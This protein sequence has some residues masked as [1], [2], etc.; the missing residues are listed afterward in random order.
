MK[1]LITLFI[2]T[3]AIAMG[4]SKFG[5]D[6]E[7]DLKGDATISGK[8][9]YRDNISGSG[10]LK[11]MG[12]RKIFIGKD[13]TDYNNYLYY[14]ITDAQGNFTFQRLN[15]NRTYLIYVND[16]I[17]EI[18]YSMYQTRVAPSDTVTLIA[19]N[20]TI[21][22]NGMLLYVL[23]SEHQPVKDAKV[24]LYNNKEIFES[25]TA[26]NTNSIK[27]TSTDQYG[28][29]IFYNYKA[30]TYYLRAK[31][32]SPNGIIAADTGFTFS[33]K[34]I[35]KD[36]ILLSTSLS[37]KNTLVLKVV[38]EAGIVLPGIT[39]CIF[40]NPLLF[41]QENCDGKY[42]QKESGDDGM[43]KLTNLRPGDYYVYAQTTTNKLDY[44]GKAN[45]KVNASGTTTSTIVMKPVTTN[46]LKVRTLDE[47]GNL[48]PGIDFCVFNNPLR[49]N[50][51]DCTGHYRDST[52][53]NDGTIKLNNIPA[54]S[55]YLYATVAIGNTQYKAKATVAVN[56]P[57][58][59]T[60]DLI[61]KKET[62]SSEVLLTV[63]DNAG[64]PV[65]GTD[66][67]FFTSRSLWLAD[68][69]TGSVRDTTTGSNG[70]VTVLNMPPGKYYLQ[71]RVM[72]N[73]Q[74]FMKGM[75][76]VNIP[77]APAKASQTI[78]VK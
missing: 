55:Y 8:I 52:T 10:E 74:L 11:L 20:D 68:N 13:T 30:G 12:G 78:I 46:T 53:S 61:L 54:G 24:W 65:N 35:Q 48:V 27:D 28:R 62:P 14:T 33:G 56:N 18:H 63:K 26:N 31:F 51:E 5:N 69:G 75:D 39:C 36:T 16:T 50:Q 47:A 71:A 70:S 44:K 40:N 19:E 45:I 67:Y 15:R 29:A 3:L 34:G 49:F 73:N 66:I 25:D 21:R 37:T 41:N 77:A 6:F 23:N 1:K 42:Q 76:S 58:E 32:T 38:D 17:D 2:C 64:T 59:T 72:Q 43:I 7:D 4:C 22:Q 9:S 60:I 57:G